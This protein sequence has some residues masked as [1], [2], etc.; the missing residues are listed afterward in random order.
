MKYTSIKIDLAFITSIYIGYLYLSGRIYLNGMTYK[1]GND[2]TNIGF[3]IS[4]Y[5]YKG[6]I[7]NL[8]LPQ[9]LIILGA[10]LYFLL[11]IYA[12]KKH[13]KLNLIILYRIILKF[14]NKERIDK[15]LIK[16][17]V[18]RDF[19]KSTKKKKKFSL[20]DVFQSD[21]LISYLF[22]LFGLLGLMMFL[23]KL[24]NFSLQGQESS[25]SNVLNS[26]TFI[27]KN[28]QK[29]YSYICG[30]EKCIYSNKNYNYFYT[31]KKDEVE[32]F[33]LEE[34]KSFSSNHNTTAYILESKNNKKDKEYLI[35]INIHNRKAPTPYVFDVQLTTLKDQN[36][37][38]VYSPEVNDLTSNLNNISFSVEKNIPYFVY[39][40]IPINEKIESI[41]L[42]SLPSI[43]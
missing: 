12:Q 18:I 31:L 25:Y 1:S 43:Y 41:S 28:D 27:L 14:I 32:S 11:K 42:E 37:R 38:Q 36:I 13:Y 5:T 40:K 33:K 21:F 15:N 3:D 34:I 17:Q 23:L 30:K 7:V 4:D 8:G 26:S 6:F 39:F 35:Q 16:I 24:S 9:Y 2:T 29:L 10:L 19:I 22:M 20:A